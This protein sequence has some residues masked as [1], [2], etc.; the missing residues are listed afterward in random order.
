MFI[1]KPVTKGVLLSSAQLVYKYR[2]GSWLCRA[3]C[4]RCAAWLD[5]FL[6]LCLW[7]E[8]MWLTLRKVLSLSVYKASAACRDPAGCAT[9]SFIFLRATLVCGLQL[10]QAWMRSEELEAFIYCSKFPVCKKS[11]SLFFNI[12][13]T[14]LV[15]R[16]EACK[17]PVHIIWKVLQMIE[18]QL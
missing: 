14:I 9:S 3:S 1:D 17:F 16:P 12:Q 15:A 10:E 5:H 7:L 6:R 4:F 2:Y 8:R 11:K 13:L 18:L